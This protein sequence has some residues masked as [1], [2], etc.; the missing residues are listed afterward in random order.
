MKHIVFAILVAIPSLLA[1][2]VI[3]S[4]QTPG[5]GE[6]EEG[7][8]DCAAAPTAASEDGTE[9]VRPEAPD[10]DAL[11]SGVFAEALAGA[12]INGELA[13]Y[14]DKGLFDYIN[15]AAPLYIERGFRRL[16]AAEL[17][18]QTGGELTGEVYDM[19][20]AGNA[21][22]IFDQERSDSAEQVPDWPEALSGPRSFVF[23]Q[24][25]YYVKLTAFDAAAEAALPAVAREI[26]ERLK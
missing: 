23:R 3:G 1:G 11:L 5:P 18:L 9:T 14:D 4:G 7:C 19:R 26:R 16:A 12:R 24:E 8:C 10:E 21:G 20:E 22:S 6:G 15:G 25:R 2:W 17:V 13:L